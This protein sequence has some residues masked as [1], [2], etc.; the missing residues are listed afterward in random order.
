MLTNEEMEANALALR[1]RVLDMPVHK[2]ITLVNNESMC[3]QEGFPHV[4]AVTKE[5]YDE[6]SKKNV[7]ADST[8]SVEDA[9]NGTLQ[10]DDVQPAMPALQVSLPVERGFPRSVLNDAAEARTRMP[11][12]PLKGIVSF[13]ALPHMAGELVVERHGIQAPPPEFELQIYE[14]VQA[15]LAKHFDLSA[16]VKW[17]RHNGGNAP[18]NYFEDLKAAFHFASN[19]LKEHSTGEIDTPKNFANCVW[20]LFHVITLLGKKQK[21]SP[22]DGWNCVMRATRA[23]VAMGVKRLVR[24]AKDNSKLTLHPPDPK[25]PLEKIHVV[26]HVGDATKKGEPT[27][28]DCID[29]QKRE[30]GLHEYWHANV[31]DGDAASNLVVLFYGPN[32]LSK[33]NVAEALSQE[34]EFTFAANH[35]MCALGEDDVTLVYRDAIVAAPPAASSRKQPVKNARAA[36]VKRGHVVVDDSSSKKRKKKPKYGSDSE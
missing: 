7:P 36:P 27:N 30:C 26:V 4:R 3:N 5:F 13:A 35:P 34:A 19:S 11:Y 31:T 28:K 20:F 33:S 24:L 1:K 17:Q 8:V 18:P 16:S 6:L 12:C 10:L 25:P 14:L 9:L 22:P 32:G 2:L 29:S 23:V 15:E 21:E